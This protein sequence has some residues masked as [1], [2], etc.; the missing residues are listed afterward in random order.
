MSDAL[1]AK[2]VEKDHKKKKTEPPATTTSDNNRGINLSGT[3][4]EQSNIT[5]ELFPDFEDEDLVQVLTQIENENTT[6]NKFT[7]KPAVNQVQVPQ[8]KSPKTINYSASA[9]SG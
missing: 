7:E 1:A 4:N 8:E 9:P 5:S 2:I 3:D 6:M